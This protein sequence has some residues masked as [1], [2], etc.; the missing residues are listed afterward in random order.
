MIYCFLKSLLFNKLR[1]LRLRMNYYGKRR[2]QVLPCIIFMADGRCPHGG[3]VDRFKG[4]VTMY[5][6]SKVNTLPFYINYTSP[7]N[8]DVVLFP[9]FYDWKI[10]DNILS[11][12][13]YGTKII[14]A[15][16]EYKNPYRIFFI[17]KKKQNHIYYG[18]NSLDLI[19]SKYGTNYEWRKL[20]KELFQPSDRL[21]EYINEFK[22]SVNGQ[23]IA[24]HFRF[25]NLLGDDFKDVNFNMAYGEDEKQS[26]ILKCRN[27]I[28]KIL[29]REK[30]GTKALVM[31]DSNIFVDSVKKDLNVYVIPGRILHVDN[32][33]PDNDF[34]IM[35]PFIDFYL[36]SEA[37]KVFS[38]KNKDMYP[39]GFPQYAAKVNN[40]PFERIEL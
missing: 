6:L 37:Q 27:E 12:S 28:Q 33:N 4:I 31:S 13:F 25:V 3:I 18:Y 2:G 10:K 15:Y 17:D 30:E 24:I 32:Q 1:E 38:I 36:I 7:F 39:S 20:F 34:E 21:Q 16:S 40:I 9:H 29:S 26:L 8:I 19:N 35:K 11:H 23:Y 22:R 14:V 5:A